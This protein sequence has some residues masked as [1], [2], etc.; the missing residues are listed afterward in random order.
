MDNIY[1]VYIIMD[2]IIYRF[3]EN[4]NAD[5]SFTNFINKVE[6]HDSS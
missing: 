2:N 5:A 3:G 1:R 6:G 4:G